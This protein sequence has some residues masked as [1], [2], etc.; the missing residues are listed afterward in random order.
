M[1][2]A[3]VEKLRQHVF[4]PVDT[5]CKVVYLLC[6]IRKLLDKKTTDPK[7]LALRQLLTLRLFCNW[8]LHVN[9]SQQTTMALLEKVDAF[10]VG[11]NAGETEATIGAEIHLFRDFVYLETFRKELSQ[12]LAGYALP[13][14]LCDENEGWFA[15]L[16]AYAGIIED[17]SLTCEGKN[18]AR[19]RLVKG[20]TFT[21]SQQILEDS[22]V[23]FGIN[24]TILLK[25]GDEV[26]VVVNAPVD[27]KSVSW[28][29][30]W[31]HK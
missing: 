5:E 11:R 25:D 15:F 13:T 21:K 8:A 26:E 23:P 20:V 27:A 16:A 1:T 2:D 28:S 31:I 14:S 6:E 24:W 12:F 19:L 7:V 10:V 3:I 9:L 17:G 22:H 30:R 18:L 29:L 4:G